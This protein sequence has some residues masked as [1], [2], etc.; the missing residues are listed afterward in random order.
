[1]LYINFYN[2]NK[3]YKKLAI[4]NQTIQKQNADLEQMVALRTETIRKKNDKLKELAYFNSHQIRKHTANIL[5]LILISGFEDDK[6]QYFKMIENEAQNL[7]DIIEQINKMTS[8]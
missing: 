6:N 5:G 2:K 8:D 3:A 7:E 1:L 4:A